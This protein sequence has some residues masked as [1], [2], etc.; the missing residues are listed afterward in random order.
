[1]IPRYVLSLPIG[2]LFFAIGLVLQLFS[3]NHSILHF[4]TGLFIGLSIVFNLYFLMCVYKR[5]SNRNQ[6][7]I[8]K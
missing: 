2:G 3:S 8:N 5:N 7:D 6:M 4:L 1:M